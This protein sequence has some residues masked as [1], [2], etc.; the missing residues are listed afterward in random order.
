MAS[1]KDVDATAGLLMLALC[2]TWGMQQVLIKAIAADISPIMQIGLRSGLA[3]VL[4]AGLLAWRRQVSALWA[5]SVPAGCA[6]GALFALEYFFAGQGLRFTSA[7]H[8]SI[9]LYTAPIFTA[10]GLHFRLPEERLARM[11]WWG[12]ALAFGGIVVSFMGRG[13]GGGAV[14]SLVWVGDFLGV[15]AGASWGL[16]TLVVRFSSLSDAPAAVTLFWQLG[17]AFCLLVPMALGLGQGAVHVDTRV[18]ADMGF[19]TIGITFVSFMVW[20]SLL[21]TY[22]AS[23]LS[24]LSFMTPLFGITFGAVF[25]HEPLTHAFLAG[26]VLILGGIMLVSG[27]TLLRWKGARAKGIT[28]PFRRP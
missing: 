11:Q 6:V 19:Q 7:A 27:P 9:F 15:L 8:M 3:A 14:S 17:G 10:L 22:L 16:T 2:A 18:V 24:V 23:R 21:R 5:V 28:L 13:A 25:L 4:V 1:R 20:F 26:A 12:I